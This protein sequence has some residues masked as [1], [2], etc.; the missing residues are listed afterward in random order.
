MEAEQYMD[1]SGNV[2]SLERKHKKMLW[3]A[4]WADFLSWTVLVIYVVIFA[5][6]LVQSIQILRMYSSPDNFQRLPQNLPSMTIWLTFIHAFATFL[7]GLF[8][9]LVLKGVSVA[10]KMLLETDLNYKLSREEESHA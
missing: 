5:A 10:L 1:S 3:F 4:F 6:S 9:T 2:H 7:T 8:Y